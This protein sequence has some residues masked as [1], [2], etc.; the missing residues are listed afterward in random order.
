VVL[1]LGERTR[2]DWLEIKWP[3]PSGLVQ[4]Y[5]EL[6]LNRYITIVE[7]SERWE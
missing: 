7:G 2:I 6:P 3:P 1:G 5:A 4:R